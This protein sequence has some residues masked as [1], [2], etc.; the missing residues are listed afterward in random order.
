MFSPYHRFEKCVALRRCIDQLFDCSYVTQEIRDTFYIHHQALEHKLKSAKY[1]LDKLISLCENT[2]LADLST[3]LSEF[4]FRGNLYIDGFFYNGGSALDI[5]AR[6]ILALYDIHPTGDIY[7]LAARCEISGIYPSDP[8]LT[9]LNTPSW[10][11]EFSNY[12]NAAT[13]EVLLSTSISLSIQMTHP[14][15][16]QRINLPLPDDPRVAPSSRTFNRN[17]DAVEYC[18]KTFKRLLSHINIVYGD[19]ADRAFANGRLP[20]P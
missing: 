12:R 8:L 3:S 16:V 5:F 20:L 15:Q 7:Y 2:S 17:P 6:E 4:D 18:S 14:S 10:K 1:N 11:S 9:R 19:I 13:H